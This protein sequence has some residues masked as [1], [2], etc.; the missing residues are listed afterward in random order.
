MGKLF[1]TFF[2]TFVGMMLVAC[3]DNGSFFTSGIQTQA[4]SLTLLVDSPQL[5]SSG[6]KDTTITAIVKDGSNRLLADIPVTFS[7]TSG[8]LNTT[9][10]TTDASGK[11]TALLNPGGD[12]SNRQITI[13]ATTGTASQSVTVDVTGT[14]ISISGDTSM[15]LNSTIDLIVTLKDSDDQPISGQTITASSSLGNT[16]AASTLTTNSNGQVTVQVTATQSGTDTLTFTGLGVTTSHTLTISGDNFQFTAPVADSDIPLNTSQTVTVHWEQNGVPQAGKT[17]AFSATRGSL[18]ANTATTNASGDASVQISSTN[19]G[20]STI[21]ATVSGGPSANRSIN[22]I[23]T[24]AAVVDLQV[25]KATIGPNDGSQATQQQATLTAT[26]R[27]ANNNLVKGKTVRFSILQ[28][29]SGGTLTASTAVTDSLG[30]ASTT[31]VSS[32]ATTAQNG[33]QIQVSVDEGTTTLTNTVSLTVARSA[34]FVRL[35][36]GNLV[37]SPTPTQYAKEYSVMITDASGNAV[38][39]VDVGIA[40]VPSHFAKGY[41]DF[42]T[43]AKTW[44]HNTTATCVNEDANLNGILDSGEDTNGNNVL[45]PGNVASAPSTV[46]TGADGSATFNIT[47]AKEYATW[48]EVQLKASRTVAG[49]E[50][51]HT[52]QFYLPI[53]GDDVTDQTK[54]P[55]GVVS[56]FGQSSSC[57]DTL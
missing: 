19:A 3:G 30:R 2:A 16:I 49:T 48:V 53:S 9:Q 4:G 45:D 14:T 5:G 6:S 56:P 54:P 20:P 35:G 51:S 7:A 47:Y 21:T 28:D 26:V 22:F 43:G 24:T 23:A 55:P 12:K 8:T 18:T 15:V 46:T 27:D 52:V 38:P 42:P 37:A 10:P 29:N 41:W 11:A 44:R 40:I 50:A 39:N 33:V 25:D 31:Y 1:R 36:T 13:T 57:A 34:L 32:S 17:I